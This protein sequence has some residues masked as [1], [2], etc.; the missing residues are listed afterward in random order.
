MEDI[1]ISQLN[2]HHSN[3]Y[4]VHDFVYSPLLHF[5]ANIC[6][7]HSNIKTVAM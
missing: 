6:F 5:T 7:N 4:P 2:D 1:V 3:N